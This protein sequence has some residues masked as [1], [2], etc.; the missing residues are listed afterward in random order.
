MEDEEPISTIL[1]QL[2]DSISTWDT[3]QQVAARLQLKL[4]RDIDITGGY[5]VI[6]TG[7]QD[8]LT[9]ISKGRP[10]GDLSESNAVGVAGRKRLAAESLTQRE[11]SEC[12]H[13]A[14]NSG[15]IIRPTKRQRGSR[16]CREFNGKGH[17][18]RNCPSRIVAID[19]ED[20]DERIPAEKS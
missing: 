6:S 16:L 2:S 7:I 4:I 5:A 8:S 14:R 11:L 20:E 15:G 13:V 12:E 3:H 1:A 17:D 19:E 10:P 9:I 18:K